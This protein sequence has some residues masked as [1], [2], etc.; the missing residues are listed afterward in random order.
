MTIARIA[1]AGA[2]SICCVCPCFAERSTSPTEPASNR[3]RPALVAKITTP[4][5]EVFTNVVISA[6]QNVA[7]DSAMDY[8]SAATVAVTVQCTSCTSSTTSLASAGLILQA[9]WVVS[10]DCSYVAT[11]NKAA[12]TFPYWDT[13][14]AIFDVYAPQ[15]RLNLQNKGTQPIILQ[16]VT[17]FRRSQ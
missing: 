3:T 13:G 16:Q 10:D 6:G 8:S 1:I 2:F 7:L 5:S 15:F 4:T 17:I 12:T 14:A 9:R 11:E